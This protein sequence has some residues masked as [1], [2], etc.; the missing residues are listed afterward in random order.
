[1]IPA[2]APARAEGAARIVLDASQ[3]SLASL[4]NVVYWARARAPGRPAGRGRPHVDAPV[5]LAGAVRAHVRRAPA[6]RTG[7][8]RDVASRSRRRPRPGAAL[9]AEGGLLLGMARDAPGMEGGARSAASCA[10]S[11]GDGGDGRRSQL[12]AEPGVRRSRSRTCRRSCARG[13]RQRRHPRMRAAIARDD[14]RGQLDARGRRPPAGDSA[15]ASSSTCA[16]RASETARPARAH[17]S[18][19]R[20]RRRA[21]R[22]RG[23]GRPAARRGVGVR[24]RRG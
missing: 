15:A 3:G 20:A 5:G 19:P 18:P 6:A 11:A 8:A 1:M 16:C 12:R 13:Q 21:G 7:V 10:W 2:F 4:A 23:L 17:A 14:E 22:R 24:L 9:G